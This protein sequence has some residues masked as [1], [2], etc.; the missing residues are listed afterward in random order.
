[1]ANI[2]FQG[3]HEEFLNDES[4]E[5]D[6]EGS[7]SCGKTTVCLYKELEM[8]KRNPGMHGLIARWDEGQVNKLLRPA[9]EQMAR[10]RGEV[11]TWNDK[12]SY[13]TTPYD[14]QI[15]S[16]GLKTQS[17]EPEQRYGKIRGLPVSRIYIDQAEQLPADIASELRARLRPD[18]EAALAGKH[19][20]HQLTFSPNPTDYDHWLAKQFPENNGIPGRRYYSLSMFDNAHNL[21][22]GMIE[23]MLIEYP[24]D[25]P[26][27][28][29]VILGKRGLNVIGEAVFD[30][31]Y[32][33]E[34]HKKPVEI[35]SE[36]DLIEAFQFGEHNPTWVVGQR[37]FFGGLQLLAGIM[38]RGLV[39]DDFLPIVKK[40]R[41][42]W[43]PNATFKTCTAPQGEKHSTDTYRYTMVNVLRS[44][45]FDPIWRDNANAPDVEL[46]MV[47]EISRMLRRRTMGGEMLLLNRDPNRWLTV[48]KDGSV[49]QTPFVAFAFEGGCVWSPH[50]V[51]ISHAE[52][53]R[54]HSDDQYANAIRCVQSLVLNFCVDQASDFEKSKKRQEQAERS[55]T[56]NMPH[57]PNAWMAL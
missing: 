45:K 56:S 19:F 53:R 21:P 32:D 12:Y 28:R 38:G 7:L 5:I 10:I 14:N 15:Y 13:Y 35:V 25:H 43:F 26:K 11:L 8:F 3:I 22:P 55:G 27:H 23:S 44:Y 42:E 51:S 36:P 30:K 1:M 46:A 41:G 29:T 52:V 49:K 37:T 39:L 24:E 33:R 9:L 16:F 2:K 18:L 57:G 34:I 50:N 6:L 47:E 54:I 17:Q 4:P 20:P 48:M 40:T 31:I